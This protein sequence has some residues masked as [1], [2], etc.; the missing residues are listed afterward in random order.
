MHEIGAS[1][2]RGGA[3]MASDG[4]GGPAL[5]CSVQSR[6]SRS[7]RGSALSEGANE[8]GAGMLP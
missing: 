1:G 4:A 6:G 8:S 3:R 2:N 5:G 7:V